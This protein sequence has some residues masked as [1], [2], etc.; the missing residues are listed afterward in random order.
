MDVSLFTKPLALPDGF[1]A[2]TRLEYE[3]LVATP[4]GREHVLEDLA[5][6][7]ASR[8]LIR[9]TRGGAWPEGEL[10]EEF[11]F[12]DLAWH[13]R[14]FRDGDSFAYAVHEQQQPSEPALYVGC[15][16]LYPMGSRTKLTTP[17]LAVH[18]VDTSWWVAVDAFERGHYQ[19]L[20]RALLVW[21]A[22]SFPF[23]QNPYLSNVDIPAAQQHE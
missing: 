21:L 22:Q 3:G 18:D 20:H 14:E 12:L 16:Y 5:A 10:T 9:R 6:V 7:N 11:N 17:Q 23:F 4:L 19:T 8:A 2:P 13:E 1:T 15:F